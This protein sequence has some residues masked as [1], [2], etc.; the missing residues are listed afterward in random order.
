[1]K[2]ILFTLLILGVLYAFTNPKAE[3]AIDSNQNDTLRLK[4][5]LVYLDKESS[6][7]KGRFSESHSYTFL[8]YKSLDRDKNMRLELEKEEGSNDFKLVYGSDG[9]LA[10]LPIKYEQ[11][12]NVCGASAISGKAQTVTPEEVLS[13][14]PM[15]YVE[16]MEVEK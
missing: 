13:Y 16:I 3:M 2:Y 5:I 7:V 8:D 14:E 9:N 10:Q 11:V 15:E 6:T 4:E 12:M 1:M